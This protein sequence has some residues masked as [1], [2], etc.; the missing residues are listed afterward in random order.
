MIKRNLGLK[1]KSEARIDGYRIELAA[2][3][4]KIVS[5]ASLSPSGLL[6]HLYFSLEHAQGSHFILVLPSK[7]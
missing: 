1:P 4:N 7:K 3:F 2:S 6:Y 5:L